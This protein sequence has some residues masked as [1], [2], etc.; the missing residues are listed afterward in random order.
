M[1]VRL[2]F[3]L[4][5]RILKPEV[6]RLLTVVTSPPVKKSDLLNGKR[7]VHCHDVA[8]GRKK[9][10]SVNRKS[11]VHGTISLPVEKLDFPRSFARASTC[12]IEFQFPQ[13]G[14]G[15]YR[16][17]SYRIRFGLLSCFNSF[18]EPQRRKAPEF[19]CN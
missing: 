19:H 10:V 14:R 12:S 1:T 8:S 6:T 17:D 11:R 16:T 9:W 5:N 18:R 15:L 2:D 7:R 13:R 3:R 4:N